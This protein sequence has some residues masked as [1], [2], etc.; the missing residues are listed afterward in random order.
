MLLNFNL[1]LFAH[2]DQ[3]KSPLNDLANLPHPPCSSS[4]SPS[5]SSSSS[6]A[7]STSSSSSFLAASGVEVGVEAGARRRR[8]EEAAGLG[9]RRRR[10][11]PRESDRRADRVMARSTLLFTVSF[12]CRKAQN[13]GPKV[14]KRGVLSSSFRVE[15]RLFVCF[16]FLNGP[17]VGD[18]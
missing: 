10:P 7:L 11:G 8:E 3:D 17:D 1:T 9:R 18:S 13:S 14:A 6:A 4:H 2:L 16:D 12:F 5:L 15:L